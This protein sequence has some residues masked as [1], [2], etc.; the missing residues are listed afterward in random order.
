MW[1]PLSLMLRPFRR[2]LGVPAGLLTLLLTLGVAFPAA[3]HGDANDDACEAFGGGARETRLQAASP[4]AS[5]PHCG[6][7][8]WLRSLRVF[9]TDAAQPLPRLA[10]SAVTVTRI[11]CAPVRLVLASVPARGPPA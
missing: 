8:H 6:I 9:Q 11:V 3:L 5:S 2:T 4:A 1:Y 10:P 7:C